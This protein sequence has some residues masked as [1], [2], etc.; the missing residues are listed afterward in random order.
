MT[1]FFNVYKEAGYTS[2]DVVAIIRRLTRGKVGHTGTLDPQAEG[3]LP[4]CLGRATKLSD[5]V[6]GQDKSYVAEVVLGVTT[7]TGDMTGQI[8]CQARVNQTEDVIL[9]TVEKF[10]GLQSQVPPMYSAIKIGG[11][12]LYELARS[13][14]TVER[15]SRDVRIES[16]KIVDFRLMENKFTIDVVCS[17]GT[18]IRSF[19]MDIGEALGCGAA[20]GSLVRTRS[21][22]F[23]LDRAYK[24]GEIKDA[25]V[26]GNLSD[27]LLLVEKVLP[28]PQAF[29]KPEGLAMAK[30]GN[31]LP[32]DLVDMPTHIDDKIWLYGPGGLIG[33][34][35]I[36]GSKLRLE[37]M[38]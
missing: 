17:K 19:C 4:I 6:M 13:G 5:M 3:V 26:A 1:G 27:M 20:M 7:D 23:S 35:S 25:A 9:D 12:R 16:I 30:N 18:Y 14:E 32:F 31:L 24:I 34:Y 29:V 8:L 15:K 21:G 11:K 38:M 37:V 22:G 10:R 28:F 36:H 33:L 2:H